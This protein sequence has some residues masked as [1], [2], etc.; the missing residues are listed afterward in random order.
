[1]TS[2]QH[3]SVIFDSSVAMGHV[4]SRGAVGPGRTMLFQLHPY[5]VDLEISEG[6]GGLRLMRGQLVDEAAGHPVRDVR[7]WLDDGAPVTRT[8]E[9]GQF[10]LSRLGAGAAVL[11]MRLDG[12]DTSCPIPQAEARR[13]RS[14]R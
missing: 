8:D 9:Y 7:V 3:A 1:M 5:S 13:R 2:F 14:V 10:S 4:G 11:W 6:P 12:R